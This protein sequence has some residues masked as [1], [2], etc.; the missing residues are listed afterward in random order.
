MKHEYL[1]T[2]QCPCCQKYYVIKCS[3]AEAA[4]EADEVKIQFASYEYFE[5][6]VDHEQPQP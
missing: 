2:V 1:P 6:R 3:H 5:L 4:S